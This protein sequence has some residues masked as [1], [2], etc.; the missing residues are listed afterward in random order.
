MEL[1]V[2]LPKSP[3]GILKNTDS[4]LVDLGQ[5]LSFCLLLRWCSCSWARGSTEQQGFTVFFHN[6]TFL[7]LVVL[8]FLSCGLSSCLLPL[9]LFFTVCALPSLC[10]SALSF[11]ASLCFPLL[12]LPSLSPLSDNLP[13]CLSP[14]SGHSFFFSLTLMC[15]TLTEL[16]RRA[17][18][19]L[20]KNVDQYLMMLM[21]YFPFEPKP[22]LAFSLFSEIRNNP[23]D[24]VYGCWIF[25][26]HWETLRHSRGDHGSL[27]SIRKA[28]KFPRLV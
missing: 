15:T 27:K 7:L 21:T 26:H 3:E 1:T 24:R 19:C 18:L 28:H 20:V 25:I 9:L 14:P 17:Q 6:V 23:K 11:S 4:D 5:A 12:C 13:L 16:H 2:V 8:P 10:I 22:K